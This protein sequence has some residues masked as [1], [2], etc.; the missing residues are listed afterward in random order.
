MTASTVHQPVSNVDILVGGTPQ[1]RLSARRALV[2]RGVQG[3]EYAIRLAIP[4]ECAWPWRCRL[5]VSTPSMRATRPRRRTQVGARSLRDRHDQR[6]ADEPDRGSPFRI[7]NRGAVLCAGAGPRRQPRR[8]LRG[9]FPGA[10]ADDQVGD[11]ERGA[12]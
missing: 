9:V 6:M 7:H 3:R 8:H 11:L 4:M 12:S 10:R 1:R 2:R 5:T